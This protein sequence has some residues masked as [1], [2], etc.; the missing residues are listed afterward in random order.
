MNKLFVRDVYFGN[1]I[2]VLTGRRVG[3]TSFVL[4][5]AISKPSYLLKSTLAHSPR[6]RCLGNLIALTSTIRVELIKGLMGM[7][8]HSGGRRGVS[9]KFLDRQGFLRNIF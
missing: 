4:Y 6:N 8:C 3:V 9:E 7:C 5:F 2:K 1:A